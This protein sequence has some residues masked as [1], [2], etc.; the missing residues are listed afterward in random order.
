VQ[1]QQSNLW[2]KSVTSRKQTQISDS[3]L[4]KGEGDLGDIKELSS[5]IKRQG[6]SKMVQSYSGYGFEVPPPLDHTP[7]TPELLTVLESRRDTRRG[8]VSKSEITKAISMVF[9]IKK[10]LSVFDLDEIEK[11]NNKPGKKNY[12]KEIQKTYNSMNSKMDGA[13]EHAGQKVHLS[14]ARELWYQKTKKDVKKY[15]KSE[16]FQRSRPRPESLSLPVKIPQEVIGS[17]QIIPR[18]KKVAEEHPLRKARRKGV[19]SLAI[20]TL[21][22]LKVDGDAHDLGMDAEDSEMIRRRTRAELAEQEKRRVSQERHIIFDTIKKESKKLK[23]GRASKATRFNNELKIFQGLSTYV[24]TGHLFE[25]F[26]VMGDNQK[27]PE[28]DNI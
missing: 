13:N 7:A 28:H 22:P 10:D 24:E 4:P 8:T 18:E 5:E 17:C 2:P 1:G 3:S 23:L 15:F 14:D 11:K 21:T 20:K 16:I 9:D 19:A 25:K 26:N 12:D 27:K 6:F